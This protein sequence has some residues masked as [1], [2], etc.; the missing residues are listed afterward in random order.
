MSIDRRVEQAHPQIFIK[1]LLAT[2]EIDIG[3]TFLIL[4][5]VLMRLYTALMDMILKK[6]KE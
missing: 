1:L 5:H 2:H 3:P 4:M 6:R